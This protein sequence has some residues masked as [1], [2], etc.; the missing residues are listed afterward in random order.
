MGCTLVARRAGIH[1][2]S[3]AIAISNK[4]TVIKQGGSVG[5]TSKRRVLSTRE[6]TMALSS[7]TPPTD[8]IIRSPSPHDNSARPLG[9]QRLSLN[10]DSSI[11]L[12]VMPSSRRA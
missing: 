1:T 5:S 4:L 8:T 2:D 7:P 10:S 6:P 3:P 11:D 12:V 9:R